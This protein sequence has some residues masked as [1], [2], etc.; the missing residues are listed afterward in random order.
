[1]NSSTITTTALLLAT[2]TLLASNHL[3]MALSAPP[4]RAVVIFCHG[5]GDNGHGAKGYVESVAPPFSVS[6]LED[7]GVVFEYPSAVPRSYRL[8]GGDISSVWYDRIGGMDPRNP[9]DTASIEPSARQL[10]ELIDEVV[11]RRGVPRERVALGG[12]S[13]GGGI[14]IQAAARTGGRLGA[15]FAMSSY[16]C[17]DSRVWFELLPGASKGGAAAKD[18][19]CRAQDD[20]ETNALMTTPVFMSHGEEDD[21]VLPSW[22]EQTA[23]RLRE[24]GADVREFERIPRAGHEMIGEELSRLFDFL[25]AEL[26]DK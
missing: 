22:G 11:E 20:G 24:G 25:R 3:A 15:V 10:V 21:F 6:A 19:R 26:L 16:L 14:A 8:M 2:H 13:M 4:P 17:E 23:R 12:F 9:E 5:S 18:G 1:M 7:A